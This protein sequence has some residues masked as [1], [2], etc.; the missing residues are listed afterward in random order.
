MNQEDFKTPN[1]KISSFQIDFA[2]SLE[3]DINAIY[4][5]SIYHRCVATPIYRKRAIRKSFI[6]NTTI[7]SYAL[8]M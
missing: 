5:F 8:A 1:E 7:Y 6:E 2:I 3:G 4:Y